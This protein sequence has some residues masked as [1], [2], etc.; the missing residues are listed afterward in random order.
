MGIV[1]NK[2]RRAYERGAQ[3]LGSLTEIYAAKGHKGL[4]KKAVEKYKELEK[5]F[6]PS[7]CPK[8]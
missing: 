2:H 5:I 6:I 3:L 8:K 1:S 7:R 4:Y